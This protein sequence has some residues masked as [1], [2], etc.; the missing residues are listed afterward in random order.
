MLAV[1]CVTP[2]REVMPMQESC[3]MLHC[4]VARMNQQILRST[5]DNF[6]WR[7]KH[8]PAHVLALY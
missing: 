8:R 4:I 6:F 5:Q 7:G 2:D 1:R 3:S